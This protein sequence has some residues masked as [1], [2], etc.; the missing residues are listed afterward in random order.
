MKFTFSYQI[1]LQTFV[2]IVTLLLVSVTF[3]FGR[4]SIKTDSNIPER[5]G[6]KSIDRLIDEAEQNFDVENEDAIILLDEYWIDWLQDG[7]L[8]ETVHRIV[9]LRNGWARGHFADHRIPFDVNR[10]D[11][12]V[13]A[14][15][16]WRDNQWWES[17]TTAVVETLPHALRTAYDYSNIRDMMLLHDGVEIPCIVEWAYEIVEKKP[18][19]RK[20]EGMWLFRKEVPVVESNLSFGYPVR[21][22]PELVGSEGIP[23]Y[24]ESE[25]DPQPDPGN[26]DAPIEILSTQ[27]KIEYRTYRMKNL[28]A[29]PFQ[30]T[31]DQAAYIPHVIWSNWKDWNDYGDDLRRNFEK[32]MVLSGALKDSLSSLTDRS[33]CMTETIKKIAAFVDRNTRYIGYDDSDFLW[34]PRTAVRTFETAYGHRLD[35]AILAAALYKAAGFEIFPTYMSVGYGDVN[36]G[37]AS[38]G[39]FGGVG[40]WVSGRD[41]VEAFFDPASC[42]IRNGL[43]P[44]YS[45]TVWIPGSGDDP[46]VSWRGAAVVSNLEIVLELTLDREN[47]RWNGRGFYKAGHGFNPHDKV[48]GVDGETKKYLQA[49]VSG[50]VAGAEIEACNPVSFSRFTISLGFD[51]TIPFGEKDAFDRYALTIAEPNDGIMDRIP[52][53]VELHHAA[54][55]SPLRLPGLFEQTIIVRLDLD[56]NAD[57]IYAPESQSIEN[58]MGAFN[59]IGSKKGSQI[60][61]KRTLNL[62]KV[63]CA[64]EEW[65]MMKSLLL[66]ETDRRNGIVLW[67]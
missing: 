56:E 46:A 13:L 47:E 37:I 26:A 8:K 24:L 42:T 44:I 29:L 17:G 62:S 52:D 49:V 63:D 20:T 58:E 38:L 61:L 67:K 51:F 31:G 45:R 11:F 10:Q 32:A 22:R 40:I 36:E 18:G 34:R 35:R 19:K 16:T 14:L 53:G 43:A 3:L 57:V 39:R 15:R 23:D 5:S 25:A 9:W 27:Q 7:R 41:E 48:T 2:A 64:P 1:R 50:L 55:Q 12:N 60:E 33:F 6:E 59:L 4:Q 54:R 21:Y 30:H 65:G 28:P 66:E